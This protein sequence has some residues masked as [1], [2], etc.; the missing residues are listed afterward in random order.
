MISKNKMAA[1]RGAACTKGGVGAAIAQKT[2]PPVPPVP[3]QII[4]H[5]APP[6]LPAKNIVKAPNNAG[7]NFTQN[8]SLPRNL[9]TMA[10]QEMT[11]GAYIYPQAG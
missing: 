6:N 5:Q 11:G 4:H 3:L 9:M 8:I 10:I 2:I 7:K 1:P